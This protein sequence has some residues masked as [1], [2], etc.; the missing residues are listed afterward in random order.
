MAR[1][2]NRL[3]A[4]AVANHK[5]PGYFPDGGG[6]YLQVL[7][8]GSK[9][10][11]FRYTLDKRPRE[12]GL[13][14]L[15]TIELAEARRQATHCRALLIDRIDPIETRKAQSRQSALANAQTISFETCATAYIEAHRPSWKNPKHADQWESTLK[16]YCYPI[17]GSLPVQLV[18]TDHVV[19]ILEPIWIQKDETAS[20]VRGRIERILDWATAKG[21]RTGEN[22]A[23]FKGHLANLLPKRKKKKARVRHHP[24]LPYAH[25]AAFVD[26]L[27]SREGKAALALEFTILTA[28]RSG[29]VLGSVPAEFDLDNALWTI[30][31]SRMKAEADHRVPLSPRALEI[32]T[33]Q[34]KQGEA[35]L[36]PGHKPG[37]SLSSGAMLELLKEM[38]W[39]DE[40][41]T[42]ITAHGFRTT[43]RTWG[44]DK[45]H[46]TREV[47]EM[48]LAHTLDS[49]VE[50]T[51]ARSDMFEKRAELMRDWARFCNAAPATVT[52]IR[53]EAA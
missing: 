27:R 14:S 8:S 31:A 45:T 53:G 2:I 23:R 25:I 28:A 50:A 22:P 18:D 38:N 34:L 35:Y 7:P 43:F 1:K 13:G 6:L 21:Y 37:T 24:A 12:M 11:I 41:G 49:D 47:L 10:W 9:S 17:A 42:R 16:T 29:E 40:K 51:Y 44:G 5:L 26:A 33:E 48:A 4:K 15:L 46:H 52:S 39:K 36:F 32:A 30:P 3:S 20:R 19:R